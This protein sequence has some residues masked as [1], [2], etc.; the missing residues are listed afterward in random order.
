MRTASHPH[1][2]STTTPGVPRFPYTVKGYPVDVHTQTD[3]Q[4]FIF[5]FLLLFFLQGGTNLYPSTIM[6]LVRSPEEVKHALLLVLD[7][8][9]GGVL[10]DVRRAGARRSTAAMGAWCACR[11]EDQPTA[12][13]A[14]L[15]R[16]L[17]M[18]APRR[19]GRGIRESGTPSW[20]GVDPSYLAQ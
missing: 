11:A 15:P 9:R 3:L 12:H 17:V 20:G 14:G 10:A 1:S 2:H 8:R 13:G 7:L 19:R 5:I 16:T 6:T 18:R 4:S